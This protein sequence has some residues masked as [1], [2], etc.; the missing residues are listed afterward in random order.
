MPTLFRSQ[1]MVSR[2]YADLDVECLRPFDRL[3]SSHIGVALNGM[4]R[5]HSS[6]DHDSSLPPLYQYAFFGTMGHDPSFSDSIPNA[7]MAS[8]PA[9]PFFLMPL[10]AVVQHAGQS[11]WTA[12]HLTGPVALREQIL[13]YNSH[14]DHGTKLI[15]YLRKTN[16]NKDYFDTYD[17]RHSIKLLAPEI[18]YP[19]AWSMPE[20]DPRRK[21]CLMADGGEDFDR[22]RCKDELMVRE[23]GSYSITYWTHTWSTWNEGGHI[24]SNLKAVNRTKRAAR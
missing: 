1:L 5:P 9:H 15:S 11:G 20:S 8:T 6:I 22:E 13:W 2:M 14:H 10:E 12:E 4:S 7:W 3:F 21:Y 18:I 16:M 17:L 23:N 19:F 24:E